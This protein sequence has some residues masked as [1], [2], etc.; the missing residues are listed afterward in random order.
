V[1]GCSSDSPTSPSV[2]PT[3]ATPATPTTPPAQTDVTGAVSANHGH[4]ARITGAQLTAGNSLLLDIT[5]SANHPHSVELGADELSQVA[6]GQR[7]SKTSSTNS[8]HNHVVT[9]N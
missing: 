2:S 4:S 6:N 5:G 9:F 1:A 7:V 3:P 8:A